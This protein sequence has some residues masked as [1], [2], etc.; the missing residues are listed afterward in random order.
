MGRSTP[1]KSR[2]RGSGPRQVAQSDYESDTAQY[3]EQREAD[4]AA[5]GANTNPQP[6]RDNTELSLRVLRRYRPTIQSILA[7]AAN[8]VAYHFLESTQAW[9]KHGV[10]GTLFVCN[11]DPV[12]TPIGHALPHICIFILNRRSMDN[13]I[14]D[15]L[16]VTDCEVVGELIVFRLA[17]EA[18]NGNSAAG[19]DDGA[20]KKIIGLWLHNDQSN[21]REL[22]ANLITAAWQQARQAFDAYLQAA[23]AAAIANNGVSGGSD[24]GGGKRLSA[25]DLYR[26]NGV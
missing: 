14:I 12:V 24:Y 17:D 6:A 13:L 3:L 25:S 8:A 15:L 4:A 22:H 9:E 16:N 5:S 20:S 26:N 2:Q 10:E 1:R 11:Q 18:V 19:D 7:V 23:T 21:T